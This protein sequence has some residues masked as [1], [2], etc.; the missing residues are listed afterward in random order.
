MGFLTD[1]E[2]RQQQINYRQLFSHAVSEWQGLTCECRHYWVSQA[3]GYLFS[4]FNLFVRGIFT[5]F[6]KG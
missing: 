4:G 6:M 1:V 2:Y 3:E 5:T